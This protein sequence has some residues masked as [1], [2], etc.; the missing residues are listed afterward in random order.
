[1]ISGWLLFM[2]GWVIYRKKV[3]IKAGC[4]LENLFPC[5]GAEDLEKLLENDS[6]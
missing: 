2:T 6:S 1:M 4:L 3:F 5:I